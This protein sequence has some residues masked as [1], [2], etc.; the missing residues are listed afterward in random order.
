MK[1]VVDEV[2]E[3]GK[4]ASRK[5]SPA[6]PNNRGPAGLAQRWSI[7]RQSTV[8]DLEEKKRFQTRH[9]QSYW[10]GSTG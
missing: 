6:E 5:N 7:A 9:R 10:S 2:Q 1:T 8:Q 4:P 3:K